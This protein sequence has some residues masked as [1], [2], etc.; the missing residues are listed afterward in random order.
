MSL[1]S[2]SD[3]QLGGIGKL[4]IL[5][6]VLRAETADRELTRLRRQVRQLQVASWQRLLPDSPA[7]AGG[8]Y[9]VVFE[10]VNANRDD[11][12]RAHH[13]PRVEDIPEWL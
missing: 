11:F 10:L 12:S 7:G 6:S 2:A 3:P 13:A 5:A 4:L 8:T 1:L 9:H